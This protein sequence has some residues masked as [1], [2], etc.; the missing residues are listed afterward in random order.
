MKWKKGLVL[1]R[2]GSEHII[3]EPDKGVV[4]MAKVYT[5]NEAAAWLWQQLE[6]REFTAGQMEEL[7]MRRYEVA[8]EQVREDVQTL[9]A[10]LKMQGL[11]V[12]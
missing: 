6:E 3:I 12:E 7:L 1:R 11:I 5:L 4:D 8:Y 2:I 9:V 10:Q